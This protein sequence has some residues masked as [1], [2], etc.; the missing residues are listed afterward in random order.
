MRAYLGVQ[1]GDSSLAFMCARYRAAL[2]AAGGD[3][4]II[5]ISSRAFLPQSTLPREELRLCYNGKTNEPIEI[6]ESKR[7]LVMV[8]G[9]VYKSVAQLPEWSSRAISVKDS[10]FFLVKEQTISFRYRNISHNPG[11]RLPAVVSDRIVAESSG[12]YRPVSG[13]AGYVVDR[14]F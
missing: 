9:D 7:T 5:E 2:S 1:L 10:V 12:R 13:F 8:P 4:A 14:Q 11:G 3:T 6:V